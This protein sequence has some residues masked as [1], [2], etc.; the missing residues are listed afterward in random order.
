MQCHAGMGGVL[1]A[2]SQELSNRRNDAFHIENPYTSAVE[3]HCLWKLKTL[4]AFTTRYAIYESYVLADG[5]QPGTREVQI[6]SEC[7]KQLGFERE[8]NP[9]AYAGTKTRKWTFIGTDGT[10][11]SVETVPAE[12]PGPDSDSLFPGTDTHN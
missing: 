2:A 3:E 4:P 7:L 8:K 10:D 5:Q 6:M 11:Q 12:K 1:S 9:T